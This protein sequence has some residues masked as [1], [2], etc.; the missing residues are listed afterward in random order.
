MI[1]GGGGPQAIAI[2]PQSLSWLRP[3]WWIIWRGAALPCGAQCALIYG[4]RSLWLGSLAC[5]AVIAGA[6]S[7]G[8][9]SPKPEDTEVWK[10]V[11]RVVTPGRTFDAPPSD[12]IVLFDGTNLDGWVSVRDQSPAKWIVADG[13]VTVDKS[14]GDI[15]TRRTFRNYQLHLEYRIPAKRHRQ[16]PGARE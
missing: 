6:A 11:P 9:Q 2:P 10:P 12:A 14:A 7:L 13:V 15:E 5:A 1:P 4:M 8:A 16:R 3:I